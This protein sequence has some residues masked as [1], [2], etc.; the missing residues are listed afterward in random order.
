MRERERERERKRERERGGGRGDLVNPARALSG[1]T[2]YHDD[3]FFNVI[4]GLVTF[5]CEVQVHGW[6]GGGS[7]LYCN[8]QSECGS[9]P[10]NLC[11]RAIVMMEK[12]KVG[13]FGI[14]IYWLLGWESKVF[15]EY[16]QMA[17]VVV[18]HQKNTCMH[19]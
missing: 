19:Q 5:E 1:S 13:T 17:H 18:I 7:V 11:V 4:K 12:R 9:Y 10:L 8:S 3:S 6:S 16:I 14:I 15:S 2:P